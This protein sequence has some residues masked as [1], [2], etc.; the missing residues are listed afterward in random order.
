VRE[1]ITGF[2]DHDVVNEMAGTELGFSD[3]HGPSNSKARVVGLASRIKVI[4]DIVTAP[5]GLGNY[6]YFCDT[7]NTPLRPPY[8]Y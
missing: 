8:R 5:K 7:P 2:I 6:V 1:C 3:I 4:D